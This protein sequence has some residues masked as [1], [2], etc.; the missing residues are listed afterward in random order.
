MMFKEIVGYVRWLIKEATPALSR[1]SSTDIAGNPYTGEEFLKEAINSSYRE[2]TTSRSWPWAR[3]TAS[4]EVAGG[5]S[6][7]YAPSDMYQILS[8]R[9]GSTVLRCNDSYSLEWAVSSNSGAPTEYAVGEFDTS[10]QEQE[11]AQSGTSPDT[12]VIGGAGDSDNYYAGQFIYNVT[13]D[14]VSRVLSSTYSGGTNTLQ[15]NT[16]ITD[17][18]AG[19]TIYIYRNAYKI[20][21][22]PTPSEDITLHLHYQVLPYKLENDYDV[23]IIPPQYVNA[24][25]YLSAYKLLIEKDPQSA[26]I[27]FNDYKR[28]YQAMVQGE[29]QPAKLYRRAFTYGPPYRL[30]NMGWTGGSWSSVRIWG[31]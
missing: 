8:L 5:D 21:L 2:I 9:R 12:L 18:S 23:P 1:Y 14:E 19:D 16:S 22:H 27:Y 11:T 30:P 6:Y 7:F 15:L 28:I 17:Q 10:I 20:H 3:K 31:W 24:I 13:R 4:V 25:S 26:A 29:N